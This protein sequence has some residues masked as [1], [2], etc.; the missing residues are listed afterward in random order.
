MGFYLRKSFRFGPLRLNLSKRGLGLSAG[1][2]GARIGVS[3]EG[4]PYV[5]AGREGI[6]YRQNL[7]QGRPSRHVHEESPPPAQPIGER[8][9]ANRPIR[10]VWCLLAAAAALLVFHYLS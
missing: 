4:K 1:V 3:A 5:A 8:S 7:G 6:Y 2:K 10:L 9:R